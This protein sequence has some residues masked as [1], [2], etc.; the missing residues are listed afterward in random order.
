MK[1]LFSFILTGTVLASSCMICYG[2]TATLNKEN[3]ETSF[4]LYATY[5]PGENDYLSAPVNED[6]TCEIEL[7]NGIRVSV[8]DV[9]QEKLTLIIYLI[10][11]QDED[12]WEWFTAC[13]N[14]RGTRILPFEIYF[15]DGNGTRIPADKIP[16]Q[17]TLP[18]SYETVAVFALDDLPDAE[19][20]PEITLPDTF[21][22]PAAFSLDTDGAAEE[23]AL[24]S[25]EKTYTFQ[26]NGSPYYILAEKDPTEPPT[27]SPTPTEP[28]TET[29]TPTPT[30]EPTKTPTKEPTQTPTQTPTKEPTQTSTKTPTNHPS[31]TPSPTKVPS[32]SPTLSPTKTPDSQTGK[33]SATPSTGDPTTPGKWMAGMIASGI[34]ILAVYRKKKENKQES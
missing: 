5:E 28:P 2:G 15:E 22:H 4:E 11:V 32:V 14:G 10:P 30:T 19:D 13:M 17:I 3:E 33:D 31:L 25:T 24:E 16:V 1:K 26:T 9:T 18:E 6:G 20:S 8:Q 7:P 23:L 29:P 12:A 27:P 34:G 21:T